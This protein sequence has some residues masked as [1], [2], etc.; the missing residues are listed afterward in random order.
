MRSLLSGSLLFGVGIGLSYA[1]TRPVMGEFANGLLGNGVF[2][3]VAWVGLWYPLDLLFIARGY[4]Q[5]GRS[6]YSAECSPCRSSF[7]LT[8]AQC[9]SRY[10]VRGKPGAT[11]K[12]ECPIPSLSWAVQIGYLGHRIRA[13]A[14]ESLPTNRL[15][16]RPVSLRVSSWVA[17]ARVPAGNQ[18]QRGQSPDRLVE[19]VV[20]FAE[21]EAHQVIPHVRVNGA[22]PDRRNADIGMAATPNFSGSAAQNAVLSS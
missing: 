22:R 13:L 20:A 21:G 12:P 7:D 19:G 16:G 8:T 14:S 15:A 1:F 17:T 6:A 5:S 4:R 18:F 10:P 3:V 2:L 9:P 11:A